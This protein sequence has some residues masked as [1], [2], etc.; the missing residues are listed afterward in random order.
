[1]DSSREELEILEIDSPEKTPTPA[2]TI[3]NV[4]DL[5]PKRNQGDF[6]ILILMLKKLSVKI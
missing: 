6:C 5:L 4:L 3:G 1:M 2:L